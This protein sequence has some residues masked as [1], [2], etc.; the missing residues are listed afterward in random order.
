MNFY[1]F[2]FF[3]VITSD[4]RVVPLE[5]FLSELLQPLG[6]GSDPL[7]P[8]KK[9]GKNKTNRGKRSKRSSL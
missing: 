2:F 3:E 4:S 7:L 1:E 8:T 9:R 5:T 6:M